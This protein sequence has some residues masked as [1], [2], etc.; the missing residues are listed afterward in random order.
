M[1]NRRFWWSAKEYFLAISSKKK[2]EF[3]CHKEKFRN[4]V[5]GENSG[6]C[7]CNFVHQH[8]KGIINFANRQLLRELNLSNSRLNKI[9]NT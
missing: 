4:F 9:S 3:I 1:R 6:Y 7:L 2:S 8:Y 5:L